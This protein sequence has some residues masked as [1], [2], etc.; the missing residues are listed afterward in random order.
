MFCDFLFAFLQTK[1]SWKKNNKKNDNKK[2]W[3]ETP[4]KLQMDLSK[5][6]AGSFYWAFFIII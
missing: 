4:L 3:D 5:D 2:K 6:W 1:S